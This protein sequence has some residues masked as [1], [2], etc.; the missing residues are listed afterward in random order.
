MSLS[1]TSLQSSGNP[2]VERVQ[3]V[4][5]PE[6]MEDTKKK[7][8]E[9]QHNQHTYELTEM[10]AECTGSAPDGGVELKAEV[11]IRPHP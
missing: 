8:P 10:E 5:E 1:N 11:D 4:Q 2:I 9:N 3:R 7:G 6:V